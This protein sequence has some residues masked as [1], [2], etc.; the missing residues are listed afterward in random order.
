[1]F[2]SALHSA[3]L[4]PQNM[5]LA[6]ST[7]LPP[8]VDI[9]AFSSTRWDDSYSRPR[10]L[11]IRCAKNRRVF[12]F[13]E[14]LF[15]A[16]D[17]DYL[18]IVQR[19]GVNVLVPHLRI[20]CSNNDMAMEKMVGLLLSLAE[21]HQFVFWYFCPFP[22]RYT[23]PFSPRCRIYDCVNEPSWLREAVS[24]LFDE[25]EKDL[26]YSADLVFTAD[27][28][29]YLATSP[30]RGNVHLFADTSEPRPSDWD[31]LWRQMIKLV[32]ERIGG[33]MEEHSI[34]S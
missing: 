24:P 17:D 1:M 27:L 10:E 25:C 6:A 3:V 29:M 4:K 32:H 21:I 14:P 15:D 20:T 2:D 18:E 7:N 30:F 31:S 33:Q 16:P 22:V 12:Y 23:K 34:P 9:V 5:I 11:M 26:R 8:W 13:E 19:D 28:K